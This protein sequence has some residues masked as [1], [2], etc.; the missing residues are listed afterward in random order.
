MSGIAYAPH[1]RMVFGAEREQCVALDEIARLSL[2]P[3]F[4]VCFR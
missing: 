4:Y 2:G 3:A 1:R